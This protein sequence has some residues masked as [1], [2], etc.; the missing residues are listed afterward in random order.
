MHGIKRCPFAAET[1]LSLTIIV[2]T[3]CQ[4]AGFGWQKHSQKA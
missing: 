1:T 3:Q 4:L 2:T